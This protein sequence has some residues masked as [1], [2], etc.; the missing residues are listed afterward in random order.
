[1]DFD[2]LQ[3]LIGSEEL[4]ALL[5][6]REELTVEILQ[7]QSNLANVE[8]L[9]N[10][11]IGETPRSGVRKCSNCHEVGHSVRTCPK[12]SSNATA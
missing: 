12:R 3:T 5:E 1:L 7:L 9:I 6:K 10:D 4:K 8:R 11:M 2:K